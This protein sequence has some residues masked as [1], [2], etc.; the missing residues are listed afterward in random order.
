ML[1]QMRVSYVHWRQSKAKAAPA[2][3]AGRRWPL[4]AALLGVVACCGAPPEPV[5]VARLAYQHEMVSLDPHGQNDAVTGSILS[6]VYEPLVN[7]SSTQAPRP[8]LA[9]EWSQPD[10][11]TWRLRLRDGVLFHDGRP[12]S[13]DDV[14]ASFERVRFD[15][16]LTLATYLDQVTEV[17]RVTGQDGMVDIVTRTPSPRLLRRLAMVAIAPQYL[18]PQRPLGTGPYRWVSG[19]ERGPVVLQR[20]TRYWGEAPAMDEVHIS[21]VADDA[22]LA[23]L[24][25]A[26]EL[27]VLSGV[28]LDSTRSWRLPASWRLVQIPSSLTMLLGMN[29][30]RPPLH[31]PR[32]REAI[33]LAIDRRRLVEV[34]FPA[35][36]AEPA[37][38][39]VPPVGDT[40][41]TGA[42]QPT[43]DRARARA[44]LA[45]ARVEPG[46]AIGLQHLGVPAEVVAFLTSELA[47]VGLQIEPK[48]TPYGGRYRR[49]AAAENAIFAFG[50]NFRFGD[51]ANFLD[52]IVHSRDA[53]RRLGLL[54]GA[55]YSS[56]E[57]DGWI[58]SA[59]R[60]P[61]TSRHAELLQ[62]A[63]DRVDADRP[64]VPLYYYGRAALVRRPFA[65][66]VEPGL[67]VFPQAIRFESD[68]PESRPAP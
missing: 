34:S 54:N 17:R 38:A 64:Y 18:D 5:R 27:D 30:E 16:G 7:V 32:V 56:P 39:I 52:S 45:E 63:L 24:V 20:W 8:C 43:A 26:E 68:R 61:D 11:L 36:G 47:A 9:V 19:R 15:Y 40:P 33:D 44:L 58:E 31:D 41:R 10:P 67:L 23:A 48:Q 3:R 60:E 22:A 4:L 57:V 12:L 21:F 66:D 51:P 13:V 42:R 28:A 1:D 46:T 25:S 59:S 37:V 50:W 49:F 53:G 29:V 2:A 62:R 14:I 35:G 6:A 55:G 65:I